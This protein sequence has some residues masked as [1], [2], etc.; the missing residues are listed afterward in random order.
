MNVL[1]TC[2]F[3]KF[4]IETTCIEASFMKEPTIIY[5]LVEKFMK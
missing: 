1:Q 2:K 3:V 5:V 4:V